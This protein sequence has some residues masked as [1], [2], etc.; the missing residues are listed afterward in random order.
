MKLNPFALKY[1]T[2]NHCRTHCGDQTSSEVSAIEHAKRST[3]NELQENTLCNTLA[4]RLPS[5]GYKA[6]QGTDPASTKG[7]VLTFLSSLN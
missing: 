3:E 1:L 5:D 2:E 6:E 7:Q 4:Q